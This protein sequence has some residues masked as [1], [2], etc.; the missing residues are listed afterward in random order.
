[1]QTILFISHN[2]PDKYP[3]IDKHYQWHGIHTNLTFEQFSEIYHDK[4]PYAIYT[5][6]EIN[7]WKYLS[8]IF[9]IRKKWIHLN[10]L[11]EN[12]NIIPCVFS[13]IIEHQYDYQHPLLSVDPVSVIQIASQINNAFF[14]H[15]S[16]IFSSFLIIHIKIT[17]TIFI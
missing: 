1:M 14:I 8:L 9:N 10:L 6:G 2:K 11:P 13:G 15:L 17:F 12:L 16:I 5:Y 3:V 4:N 7:I